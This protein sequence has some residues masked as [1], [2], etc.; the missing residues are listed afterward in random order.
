M[1]KMFFIHIRKT[2]GTSASFAIKNLF[3]LK[4]QCPILSDFELNMKISREERKEYLGSF[5]FVSGHFSSAYNLL[6]GN[7]YATAI[8]IRDPISRV[9]SAYHHMQADTTDPL[10]GLASSR[11]IEECLEIDG[12]SHEMLNS[13]TR[14][15][16]G[17]AGFDYDKLTD[18]ER[19]EVATR[20]LDDITFLG[21]TEFFDVSISLMA[22][23]SGLKIPADFPKLNCEITSQGKKKN[24]LFNVVGGIAE[25]NQLDIAIYNHANSLFNARIVNALV[26]KQGERMCTF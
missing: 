23:Q 15:L 4:S 24:E 13:Q 14:Y 17:N 9:I 7:D 25:K 22:F 21:L 19:L 2:A 18:R 12:L 8:F 11:S 3:S 1:K 16:V 6:R 5:D 20:F 10:H 26:I